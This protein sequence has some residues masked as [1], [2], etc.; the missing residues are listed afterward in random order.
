LKRIIWL[1]GPSGAGKTTLA[2]ALVEVLPPP[3]ELLDGDALRS[4]LWPD[5][6]F[7]EDA[8]W[9][10]VRR[11][12]RVAVAFARH[13]I[14]VIV[15]SRIHESRLDEARAWIENRGVSLLCVSLEPGRTGRQMPVR[16]SWP[17]PM[18][19]APSLPSMSIQTDEMDVHKARDL[20]LA[21]LT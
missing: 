12:S 15:A 3:V 20:I 21:K 10:H 13:G 17:P 5:L 18:P 19:R 8:R 6:V 16:Q 7:T 9:A 14:L 2:S 1:T 4:A 11:L